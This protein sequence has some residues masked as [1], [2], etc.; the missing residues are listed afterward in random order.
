M[1]LHPMI[2]P[3]KARADVPPDAAASFDVALDTGFFEHGGS[4]YNVAT[5]YPDNNADVR[6]YAPA[7]LRQQ[8]VMF[9][10][11]KDHQIQVQ[12]KAVAP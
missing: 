3:F 6:G 1:N 2:R 10:V 12:S 5:F 4:W 7:L 11:I 8:G 9:F